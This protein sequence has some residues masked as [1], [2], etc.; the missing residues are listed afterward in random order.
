MTVVHVVAFKFRADAAAELEVTVQK[1]K[2]LAASGLPGL[3]KLSFGP[4]F[5]TERARG[6]T[7]ALV[8]EFT[9]REALQV[10]TVSDIHVQ[11]VT[12]NVRPLLEPVPDAS[13]ALDYEI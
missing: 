9:D 2:K 5:T 4:T 6:Y 7:H 3:I 8:A 10:Y 13:L 12:E 11:V 1:F